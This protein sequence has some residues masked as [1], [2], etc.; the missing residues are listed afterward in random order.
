[1]PVSGSCSMEITRALQPIAD[2]IRVRCSDDKKA[3]D[4]V[5]IVGRVQALQD[6]K[7]WA[8]FIVE[9]GWD[10][11]PDTLEGA[12]CLSSTFTLKIDNG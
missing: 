7:A 5:L 2:A 6:D 3:V 4:T 10:K 9:H 11:V 1:M 8:Q 12:T